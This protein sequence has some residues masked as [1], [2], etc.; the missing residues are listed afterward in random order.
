MTFTGLGFEGTIQEGQF[1]ELLGA[2]ADHGVVGTY[3][4]G[5][6]SAA[7]VA[8][9]RSLRCQPGKILVPGVLGILDT[10]TTSDVATVLGGSL[11][12]VDLLIAKFNWAAAGTITLEMKEGAPNADPKP[13]A[14]QQD[15]GV[16]FEVPIANGRLNPGDG[17]YTATTV[18]D[19]RYWI[20]AGKYVLPNATQLPPG[21][22]GA[23]AFRPDV[24]QLLAHNGTSWD[25]FKAES[26]TGWQEIAAVY[27]G[28]DGKTYGRIKNGEA[29]IIV[30]WLKGTTPLTTATNLQFQVPTAYRPSFDGVPATFYAGAPKAP[31]AV[32]L[33]NDGVLT[34]SGVVLNA[35]ASLRGSMTYPVG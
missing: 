6:M 28:F 23:L 15:P 35:G 32:T 22:A 11:P 34:M 24:H 5:S 21:K 4:D 7:K 25:T 27:P 12:R 13:P 3:N 10:A 19:R 16:I 26:D 2:I 20:E 8:G 29:T 17:E 9:A 18:V 1:A 31:V 30:P 14:V 33:G